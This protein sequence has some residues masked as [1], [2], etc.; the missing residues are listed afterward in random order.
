MNDDIDPDEGMKKF[1][2]LLGKLVRKKDDKRE[3]IE[4]DPGDED[5]DGSDA[6]A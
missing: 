2:D 5:S 6:D 3:I 1:E 4:D